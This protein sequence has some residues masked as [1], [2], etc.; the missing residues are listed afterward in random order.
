MRKLVITAL[1][2]LTGVGFAETGSI[3]A[4]GTSVSFT[5]S[6]TEQ[7]LFIYNVGVKTGTAVADTY[8][9]QVT[10]G[11]VDYQIGT[12]ST[13]TNSV[14]GNAVITNKIKVAP[15]GVYKVVRTDTNYVA[16]VFVDIR[17]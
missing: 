11:G 8:S 1:I 9:V 10:K 12:V 3:A 7:V 2:A 16:N 6:A 4:G 17:D 5:N 14:Y 15:S 13:T